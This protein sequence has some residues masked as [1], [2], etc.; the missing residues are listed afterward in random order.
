MG[1]LI[2]EIRGQVLQVFSPMVSSHTKDRISPRR[3]DDSGNAIPDRHVV[4]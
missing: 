3:V 1:G 4:V 2:S